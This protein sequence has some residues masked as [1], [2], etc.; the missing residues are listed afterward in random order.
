M[1]PTPLPTNNIRTS[2]YNKAMADGPNCRVL[3]EQEPGASGKALV[4]FY[5]TEELPSFRVK[6]IPAV[7]SKVERAHP[8]LAAAEAGNVWMLERNWN[9]E[10]MEEFVQF[11]DAKHDDQVDTCGMGYNELLGKRI[12]KAFWGRHQDTARAQARR[13]TSREAYVITGACWGRNIEKPYRK[14]PSLKEL[15][16]E[17][18]LKKEEKRRQDADAVWDARYGPKPTNTAL[19]VE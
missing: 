19:I 1:A 5:Q 12:T 11:P 16:D 15:A 13:S 4:N 10:F 2:V 17:E 9:A 8:F 3:I 7:K 6:G 18:V 14:R